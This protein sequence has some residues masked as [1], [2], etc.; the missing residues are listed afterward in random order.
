MVN[1]SHPPLVN[2]KSYRGYK[3]EGDYRSYADKAIKEVIEKNKY[4]ISKN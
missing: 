2:R 1:K 3:W 4:F